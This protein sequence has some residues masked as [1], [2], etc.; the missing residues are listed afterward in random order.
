MTWGQ[1]VRPFGPTV[2]TQTRVDAGS[3]AFGDGF[4]SSRAPTCVCA[5]DVRARAATGTREHGRPSPRVRVIKTV[6]TVPKQWKALWG[7][8]FRGDSCSKAPHQLSPAET[9]TWQR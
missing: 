1:L 3:W 6:C 4:D 8:A 5:R 7:V 2:P 9:F